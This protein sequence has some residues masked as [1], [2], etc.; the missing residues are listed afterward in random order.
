MTYKRLQVYFFL[1]IFVCSIALTFFMF[2]PYLGLILFG[3]ILA[4]L[5]GPVYQLLLKL[6][7]GQRT[8]AAFATV[9]LTLVLILLP[10]TFLVTSLAIEA[11]SVFNK[12]RSHL[13]FDDL[14]K[15]LGFFMNPEMAQ[16]TAD[17]V[18]RGIANIA[19]YVRPFF[20]GLT[21]NIYAVF[22]NTV[23]ILF[24]FFITLMSMYYMLK[25]GPALKRELL[26]LSPLSDANDLAIFD[27]IKNS[28]GAVAYGEFVV[29]IA[30]GLVGGLLF[31]A[32]GLAA[33][34]FWGSIIALSHFLPGIGTGIVTIPF[35]VY[36]FITGHFWSG[37]IL[38]LGAFLVI[39]L[40]DNFLTPQLIKNRIHIH[41]LLILLSII[42]GLS[43][44][45]PFGFFFGP[46][47]LSVT[48]ALVDIYKKEFRIYLE[49][50]K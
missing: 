34:V 40:V 23:S 25:D 6:F 41:P 29:A 1:I 20:L 17:E 35:A 30:K 49:K 4:F 36:L 50:A 31:Y 5:V 3:G 27:R 2:R 44:F 28:V 42:G 24:G 48:L 39:G 7:R 26:D 13:Q 21:S 45:G 11:V 22:S 46:I 14:Q 32:L 43:L 18:A 10:L 9:I 19:E 12:V 47:V 8:L 33:P 37:L 38:T 16:R 15:N